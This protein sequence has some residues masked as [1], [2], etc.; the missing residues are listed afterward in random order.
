MRY[1][2]LPN[3]CLFCGYIGHMEARCDF[4]NAEKKLRYNKELGVLP[5]HFDDPRAWFLPE[6]M[7]QGRGPQSP[8]PLWRAPKPVIQAMVLSAVEQV[9]GGVDRL[10]MGDGMETDTIQKERDEGTQADTKAIATPVSNDDEKMLWNL[11]HLRRPYPRR[12]GICLY[13]ST[14]APSTC[15][16]RLRGWCMTPR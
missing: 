10:S 11:Q 5:V 13:L 14:P 1:E 8:T 2:R 9:W 15:R 6:K 4:S 16:T 3:F 7:G 12:W